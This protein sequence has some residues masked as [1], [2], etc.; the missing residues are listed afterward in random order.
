MKMEELVQC[1]MCQCSVVSSKASPLPKHQEDS[2]LYDDKSICPKCGDLI[3]RSVALISVSDKT[4]SLQH[5]AI[6][7]FVNRRSS[8]QSTP[9]PDLYTRTGI[10]VFV[11]PS[12]IEDYYRKLIGESYPEARP[13]ILQAIKVGWLYFSDSMFE[14]EGLIDMIDPEAVVAWREFREELNE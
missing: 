11:V 9:F 12:F 4:F 5:D 8:G 7:C 6:Q 3:L 1:F 10:T 13:L 2:I 14:D